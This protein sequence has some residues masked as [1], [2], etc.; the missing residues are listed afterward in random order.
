[1][2]TVLLARAGSKVRVERIKKRKER[3]TGEAL[4]TPPG[5]QSVLECVCRFS[6]TPCC[7]PGRFSSFIFRASR[8]YLP[9]LD[10]LC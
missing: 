9:G 10:Y 8:K 6:S 1:M 7:L 3:V 4:Q 2:K 5:R